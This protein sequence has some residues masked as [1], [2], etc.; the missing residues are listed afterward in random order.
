VQSFTEGIEAEFS[1][2]C[3]KMNSLVCKDDFTR[4]WALSKTHCLVC[5]W[6]CFRVK[7]DITSRNWLSWASES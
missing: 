3:D 7:V 2:F 5:Q 6:A 4:T 1:P